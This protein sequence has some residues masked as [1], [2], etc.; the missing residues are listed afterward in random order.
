MPINICDNIFI[1][2]F[3]YMSE[4]TLPGHRSDQV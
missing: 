3:I 2:S 4:T 1:A